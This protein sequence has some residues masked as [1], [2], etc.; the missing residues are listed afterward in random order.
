MRNFRCV[1]LSAIR[2]TCKPLLVLPSLCA[3][4]LCSCRICCC[5]QVEGESEQYK[6]LRN[7]MM[8]QQIAAR[9]IKDEHVLQAMRD[10]PRHQLL[11]EG[12][13]EPLVIGRGEHRPAALGKRKVFL[14]VF[15]GMPFPMGLQLVS[16][17][18]S[19]YIPWVWGVNGVASVIAPVLGSLLS[20][21]LGFRVVMLISLL[22]YGSA[23]LLIDL[24][25]KGR[26]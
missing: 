3:I 23:G 15:M 13:K 22:L 1:A 10:V 6:R 26:D 9:G 18:Q 14:S 2:A 5:S 11:P 19:A 16:D 24:L 25:A 4:L 7:R 17:R 20:V 12:R 8:D 21:S